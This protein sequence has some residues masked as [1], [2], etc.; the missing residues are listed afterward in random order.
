MVAQHALRQY[1]DVLVKKNYTLGFKGICGSAKYKNF[2]VF[3]KVVA[4]TNGWDK[5]KYAINT[6]FSPNTEF[7]TSKYE[8]EIIFQSWFY[9]SF[10]LYT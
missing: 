7:P 5:I 2:T 3:V 6:I 1:S 9:K 8:D 10:H 4:V